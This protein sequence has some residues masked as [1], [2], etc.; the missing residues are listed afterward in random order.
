MEWRHSLGIGLGLDIYVS[1]NN[2]SSVELILYYQG[3]ELGNTLS[4]L[5]FSTTN[6]STKDVLGLGITY[7][8]GTKNKE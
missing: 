2:S 7:Y 1:D 6:Y 3:I 4:E 5:K 8:I